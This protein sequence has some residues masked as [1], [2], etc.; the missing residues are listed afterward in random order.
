MIARIE[1]P[2]TD[3]LRAVGDHRETI[4]QGLRG[5]GYAYVTL[6]MMGFRSGSMNEVLEE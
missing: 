6:D 4:V 2:L 5:L 1:L 3:L